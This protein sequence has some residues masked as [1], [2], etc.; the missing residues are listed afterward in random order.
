MAINVIKSYVINEME[1]FRLL[2][3][4]IEKKIQL[5]I[6]MF[7]ITMTLLL[8]QSFQSIKAFVENNNFSRTKL[9]VTIKLHLDN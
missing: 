9:L 4:S 6:R 3:Q 7:T 2:S 8:G 1:V 5:E